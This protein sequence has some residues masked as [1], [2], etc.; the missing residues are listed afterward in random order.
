M[1]TSNVTGWILPIVLVGHCLTRETITP[2]ECK[3]TGFPYGSLETD[4]A[5]NRKV[6]R[7][8]NHNQ[9]GD[10]AQSFF[11]DSEQIVLIHVL[12]FGP[13]AV[14]E[15]LE[16]VLR[17]LRVDGLGSGF[18]D[19]VVSVNPTEVPQWSLRH[20]V[21]GSIF[22]LNSAALHRLSKAEGTLAI[23]ASAPVSR[24]ARLSIRPHVDVEVSELSWIRYTDQNLAR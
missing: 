4:L 20:D 22:V 21:T 10:V 15:H 12:D 6:F 14:V 13:L 1:S 24:A 17:S 16:N 7:S 3:S 5:A 9:V 18:L 23:G 11:G 8:V 2:A 19:C